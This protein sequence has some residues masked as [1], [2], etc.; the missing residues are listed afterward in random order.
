MDNRWL[1]G[2]LPYAAVGIAC[3]GLLARDLIASAPEIDAPEADKDQNHRR[4][5]GVRSLLWGSFS[6]QIGISGVLLAHLVGLLIPRGVLLWNQQP[7]RLVALEI[8]GFGLA[9]LA[10]VGLLLALVAPGWC[11]R[12]EPLTL[13]D[14]V[15]VTLLG[16][17][18]VSGLGIAVFHRWGSSWYASVMVPYLRSL[19]ALSPKVGLMADMPFLVKLHVAT[20]FTLLAVIPF[21]RLAWLVLLPIRAL[22]RRRAVHRLA[23][24]RSAD[25]G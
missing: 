14:T 20:A 9:I 25:A 16:V 12:R 2:V 15:L 23:R 5:V 21:T 18:V 13:S 19:F 1:F 3:L 24:L 4:M 8:T 22:R 7:L 10:A 17:S 11:G 6:W